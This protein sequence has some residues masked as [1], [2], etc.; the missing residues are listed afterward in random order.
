ME[1]PFF[2]IFR[3]GLFSFRVLQLSCSGHSLLV[4]SEFLWSISEERRRS[5]LLLLEVERRD[6][7]VV[8]VKSGQEEGVVVGLMRFIVNLWDVCIYRNIDFLKYKF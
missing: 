7:H 6:S 2:V 1:N 3:V 4:D 8:K 5:D